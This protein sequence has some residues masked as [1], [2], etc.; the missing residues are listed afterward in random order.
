MSKRKKYKQT[1][2]LKKWNKIFS[3][4]ISD[5][6]KTGEKYDIKEVRKEA[7][8]S[9]LGFKKVPLSKISKRNVVKSK[10][11]KKI[12]LL[13]SDIKKSDVDK[14]QDLFFQIAENTETNYSLFDFHTQYPEIPILIKTNKSELKVNRKIGA[15]EGSE[16]QRFVNEELREEYDNKDKYEKVFSA[17]VVIQK[18]GQPF[19][20]F[21]PQDI[22]RTTLKKYLKTNIDFPKRPEKDIKIIEKEIEKREK[23]T[24]K[25]KETKKLKKKKDK[26]KT[27]TKK[28]T[29]RKKRSDVG[30]K[31][32]K[33]TTAQ[34][35]S[36]SDRNKA[37]ELLLEEFKLGLINKKEYRT[38]VKKIENMFDK[39]GKI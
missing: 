36:L 31:R 11:K 8:E 15:Y 30:K 10:V 38:K 32:K 33:K 34:P 16:L 24:K 28:P 4:L 27:T 26:N 12:T 20:L 29:I 1:I 23:T 25:R 9:Y 21:T 17:V 39:G 5:Y 37:K 3:A 14:I 18:K 35:T 22:N 7:S 2:G 13:A 6:K 19:L